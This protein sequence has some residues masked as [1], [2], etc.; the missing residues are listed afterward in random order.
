LEVSKSI[1]N[2]LDSMLNKN[3]CKLILSK[4]RF[5]REYNFWNMQDICPFWYFRLCFCDWWNISKWWLK[6]HL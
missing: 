1:N 4:M 6:Y 2:L 3:K 5:Q